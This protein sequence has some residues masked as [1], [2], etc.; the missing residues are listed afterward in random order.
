MNGLSPALREKK[1]CRPAGETSD[2][3]NI[4]LPNGVSEAPPQPVPRATRLMGTA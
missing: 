1:A 4:A 3:I 2:L